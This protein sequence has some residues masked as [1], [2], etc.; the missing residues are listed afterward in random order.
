M[1]HYYSKAP[2]APSDRG[3]VEARIHGIDL[4]FITDSQVFSK[5]HI[6]FGT[7]LMLES[8]IGDLNERKIGRGRFL[9]L[10]CGYG[11]V[12]IA[13]KRV[14][15]ALEVFMAD[16]NE[17]AIELSREN[18][19]M[20]HAGAATIFESDGFSSVEGMFDVI[21]TNPPVRAGKQTVYSFFEGAFA[22][23]NEGGLFYAVLQKKQGAPSA[24]DKLTAL[25][26][27]CEVIGK[28]AGYRVFRCVRED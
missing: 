21:M 19:S 13:M 15:P 9:D 4:S 14:F 10:G 24:Q 23:L 16:I 5:N 17:R 25:F 7:R 11:T 20:N 22:R 6:D 3:R 28:D 26:G 8:A 1:N 27:A 12:G 18:A 2:E